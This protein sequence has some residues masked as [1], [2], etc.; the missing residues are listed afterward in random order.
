MA[1]AAAAAAAELRVTEV[2][3]L[4]GREAP[5]VRKRHAARRFEPIYLSMR[6]RVTLR[7]A[8]SRL[9]TGER[10]RQRDRQAGRQASLFLGLAG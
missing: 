4:V 9:Q 2:E 3:K 5:F 8:Y 10:H 6:R 1:L 7:V